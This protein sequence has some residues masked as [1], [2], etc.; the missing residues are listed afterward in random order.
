MNDF[1]KI[2]R[3]IFNVYYI[4]DNWTQ[5]SHIFHSYGTIINKY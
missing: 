1:E 3:L 2:C 5:R 4:P